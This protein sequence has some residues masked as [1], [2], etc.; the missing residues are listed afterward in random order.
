[1]KK[2]IFPDKII[3]YLFF[4]GLFLLIISFIDRYSTINREAPFHNF[5]IFLRVHYIGLILLMISSWR[6][7]GILRKKGIE[8]SYFFKLIC[9]M[10]IILVFL[11]FF[12]FL[13]VDLQPS[14]RGMGIVF[15]F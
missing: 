5:F 12:V 10:S 6:S 4:I 2:N 8:L 9:Y 13:K 7:I 1:M 15:N 3:V 11:Y 14:T